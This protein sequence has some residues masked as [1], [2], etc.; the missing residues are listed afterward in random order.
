MI[1]S[2]TLATILGVLFQGASLVAAATSAYAVLRPMPRPAPVI[3]DPIQELIWQGQPESVQ[4]G[5]TVPASLQPINVIGTVT[6]SC[7]SV[8]VGHVKFKVRVVIAALQTSN[9]KPLG[10]DARCYQMAF[11]SYASADRDKVLTRVQMLNAVG[12]RYI[13]DV[14]NLDPG[15]RWE[16]QIYRR[17]DE[18]DLFLLFWSSAARESEWVLKEVRYALDRKGGDELRPLE[19][20]PVILEGPPLVPPPPELAHLHFN[21]R[22]LYLMPRATRRRRLFQRT[23]CET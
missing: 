17:I 12:I 18:C 15:D 3:D 1:R 10:E 2:I 4:F 5:V 23:I 21:D 7:E 8:P 20:C 6:V 11:V 9:P 22:L 13:Q 14:L 19:I 16:R